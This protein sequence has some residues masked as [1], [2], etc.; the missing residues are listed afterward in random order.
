MK[1]FQDEQAVPRRAGRAGEIG[2]A[3][4]HPIEQR[5]AFDQRQRRRRGDERDGDRGGVARR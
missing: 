2:G 3:T 1:P 5:A 4:S